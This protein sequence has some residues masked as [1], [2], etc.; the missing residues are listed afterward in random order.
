[1]PTDHEQTPRKLVYLRDHAPRPR[2]RTLRPERKP[3]AASHPDLA[4][5][6]AWLGR[7]LLTVS[8]AIAIYWV[9]ILSGAV[10]PEGEAAW[11]WTISR[12]LAHVYVAGAAALAARQ[13]LRGNPRG[14]LLVAFAASGLIVVSIE[15]LAH[16]VVNDDLSRISL[17]A[18]TDILTRTAALALGVWASSYALRAERRSMPS[19]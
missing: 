4:G 2:S 19:S 18:R 12:L 15:G 10:R 7:L 1:M 3:S 6:A 11:N 16:L 14:T 13:L 17:A 9:L 8:G 5:E